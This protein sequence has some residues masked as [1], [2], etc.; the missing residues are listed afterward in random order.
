MMKKKQAFFPSSLEGWKTARK[1]KKMKLIS[2]TLAFVM[3]ALLLSGC[4][5]SSQ[6]P[7]T[8]VKE[9]QV[10]TVDPEKQTIS[11]KG[12]TYGYTLE[13]DSQSWR[14]ELTY[15]DG[16]TYWW[17][18]Q[19]TSNNF[20]TGHGGWSDGF[21]P[22][23]YADPKLLVEILE[24]QM[25]ALPSPV[26][27]PVVVILFAVG[28]PHIIWPER[29]WYLRHGWMY[30]QAEPSDA[31]LSANRVSGVAAIGAALLLVLLR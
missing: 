14:T 28:L 7:Y 16:E 17:E 19:E 11:L 13:G 6:E 12:Q 2:L 9:G 25:E 1:G 31:A 21:D 29:C 27:W 23:G 30:R 15:P 20:S 24:E 22:A 10:F 4:G 5:A 26:N 3:A 18:R 8:T